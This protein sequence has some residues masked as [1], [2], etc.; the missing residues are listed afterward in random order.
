MCCSWLTLLN[1]VNLCAGTLV[2]NK[3]GSFVG[4]KNPRTFKVQ[5]NGTYRQYRIDSLVSKAWVAQ[6]IVLD[7]AGTSAR[8][9]LLVYSF[10]TIALWFTLQTDHR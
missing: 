6:I 3:V 5:C 4:S 10:S 9:A 8:G 7:L 2:L 1:G